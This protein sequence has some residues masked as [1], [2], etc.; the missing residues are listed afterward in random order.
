MKRRLDTVY[1]VMGF[2]G[3]FLG[4]VYTLFITNTFFTI[5]EAILIAALVAAVTVPIIKKQY[6]GLESEVE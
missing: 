6:N 5:L 4:I 3:L 2:R 1:W